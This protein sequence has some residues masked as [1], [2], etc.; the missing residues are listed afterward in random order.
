[1][2][3]ADNEIGNNAGTEDQF[4]ADRWLVRGTLV[5][6]HTW[7]AWRLQPRASIGYI[8]ET[9]ASYTSGSG[10]VLV[11]SQTVSLGQAKAGAP[12]RLPAA[13]DGRHRD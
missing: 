8:E 6:Q 12:D 11:P 1:M 10:A 2:G 9:Q 3:P 4:D 13:A 7:G 5:G